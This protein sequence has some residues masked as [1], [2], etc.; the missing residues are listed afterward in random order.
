MFFGCVFSC[1]FSCVFGYSSWLCIWYVIIV[2][3]SIRSI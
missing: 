1:V 3:S 2:L